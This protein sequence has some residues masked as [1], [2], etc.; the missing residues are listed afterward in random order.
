[1]KKTISILLSLVMLLSFAPIGF[2]EEDG[3]ETTTT[4]TTIQLS[5][6]KTIKIGGAEDDYKMSDCVG[7]GTSSA[8]FLATADE[9]GYY[10]V[11][12]RYIAYEVNAP[13]S[14]R[15]R[16]T[17]RSYP[18]EGGTIQV[19]LDEC[20][21]G[22]KTL[23]KGD[24]ADYD[25][26]DLQLTQGKHI[27][28]IKTPGGA[29]MTVK[30]FTFT[31]L[32]D[33]EKITFRAAGFSVNSSSE[34]GTVFWNKFNGDWSALEPSA[35][36][37][38][39][40][41]ISSFVSPYDRSWGYEV[42]VVETGKYEVSAFFKGVG[43]VEVR[44]GSPWTGATQCVALQ[45][46]DTTEYKEYKFPTPVS[47]DKGK[48]TIYFNYNKTNE[49]DNDP[50]GCKTITLEQVADAS[51]LE[52]INSAADGVA[53]KEIISGAN[54]KY[55]NDMKYDMSKLFMPEFVT[56]ALVNKNFTDLAA[57]KTAF[58]T[59]YATES[60]SPSV[61]LMNQ[62][63][64]NVSVPSATA[65]GNYKIV[66]KANALLEGTTVL[67]AKYANGALTGV[68]VDTAQADT[69]LTLVRPQETE[70]GKLGH[71]LNKGAVFGTDYKLFF[72]NDLEKL[73]P[74][75]LFR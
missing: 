32:G 34:S 28:L 11:N 38:G 71:W 42:P 47:L 73:Q 37:V 10:K 36:G 25:L 18:G 41:A 60:A 16:L 1:M 13:V 68:I 26:L 49:T 54:G 56:K 66:L 74:I 53:I 4:T 51:V 24:T 45:I 19:Y 22:E 15:Y 12:N 64:K 44:I 72:W 67:W 2:A 55:I 20:L 75:S 46:N 57:V 14:G 62:S 31:K 40:Y 17:M 69:E 70:Y 39:N 50:I 9:Y 33:M 59:A 48:H 43:T 5:T 21:A 27:V 3:E 6:D 61:Q 29:T 7:S 58:D 63:A 65:D 30:Y 35:V 23:S 52:N 8:N